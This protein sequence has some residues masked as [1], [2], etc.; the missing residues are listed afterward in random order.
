MIKINTKT[1]SRQAA[2]YIRDAIRNKELHPGDKLTELA[3]AHELSI[4]QGPV[5]EAIQMLVAEGL[6]S[7]RGKRDKFVAKPSAKEIR[8]SYFAGG[9]LE[10]A[11]VAAAIDNFESNDIVYIEKIVEKMKS[12]IKI[13][14]SKKAINKLAALDAEFH[15]FLFS[16]G[17]NESVRDL[18]FRSCQVVGKILFY[19]KWREFIYPDEPRKREE[20]YKRHKKVV[21][22]VKLRDSNLIEQSIREHYASAGEF[23][24]QCCTDHNEKNA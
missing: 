6:V 7:I 11:I 1:L 19:Q 4:S 12:A 22:A 21:D 2:E 14:D 3:I 23:F 20:T 8:D 5:R 15:D 17:N 10:G 9:V 18:W 16:M 13:K 24:A